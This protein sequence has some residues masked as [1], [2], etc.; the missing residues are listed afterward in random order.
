MENKTQDEK[1]L[2]LLLFDLKKRRFGHYY[3]GDNRRN[4][5]R[6]VN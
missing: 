1:L 3:S 5:P 2:Q 6:E 4:A